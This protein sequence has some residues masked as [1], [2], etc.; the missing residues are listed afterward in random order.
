MTKFSQKDIEEVFAEKE[1][2]FPI[3]DFINSLNVHVKRKKKEAAE[4]E[5]KKPLLVEICAPAII[6]QLKEGETPEE[7]IK[8]SIKKD[9][10]EHALWDLFY[11]FHGM[12]DDGSD[13]VMY[14]KVLDKFYEVDLHCEA[15]WV[16]D[17]SVRKNLPGEISVT[18]VKEVTP[19]RIVTEEDVYIQLE[20]PKK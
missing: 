7:A 2:H 10:N 19:I 15:E 4:I 11:E 17:W 6:T 9:R 12:D 5:A 8:F 18:N 1:I 14:F 20:I 16:S 13:D 3:E